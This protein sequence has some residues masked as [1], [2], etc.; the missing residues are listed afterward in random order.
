[1]K[2]ILAIDSLLYQLVMLLFES[3]LFCRVSEE[4]RKKFTQLTGIL[5]HGVTFSI[6]NCA[7]TTRLMF[8]LF[9]QCKLCQ[10]FVSI[11]HF[12]AIKALEE[13]NI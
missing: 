3:A 2:T 4:Q 13:K 10:T 6:P 5:V 8:V 7:V 9:P 11:V 12:P 1:M